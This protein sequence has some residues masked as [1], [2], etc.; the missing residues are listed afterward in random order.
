MLTPGL[1]E[2]MP[3]SL[4]LV[5]GYGAQG[6]TAVDTKPCFDENGFGALVV[7]ARGII[8]A[9]AE[10]DEAGENFVEAARVAAI[11]MNK[12]LNSVR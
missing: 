5:P 9:Y 1:S 8:Y 11:K 12:E 7:S 3:N 2:I 4:F 10:D 6:A